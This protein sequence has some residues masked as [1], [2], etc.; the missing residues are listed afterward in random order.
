MIESTEQTTTVKTVEPAEMSESP[1]NT[2]NDELDLDLEVMATQTVTRPSKTLLFA[3]F[4]LTTTIGIALS[5][6]YFLWSFSDYPIS[7]E[8]ST[9]TQPDK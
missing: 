8:T 5:A 9:S 3:I 2:S 7:P 1:A 4:L 6:G